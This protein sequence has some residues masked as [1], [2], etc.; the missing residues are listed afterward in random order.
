MSIRQKARQTGN[1]AGIA[2][3]LEVTTEKPGNVTPTHDF[4]D[5]KFENFIFGGLIIGNIVEKAFIDG[6]KEKFIPGKRIYEFVRESKIYNKTNTHFG[7]ALLFIPLAT[8]YGMMLKNNKSHKENFE[9]NLKNAIAHVMKKTDVDDVIYFHKAILLCNARVPNIEDNFDKFDKLDILSKNFIKTA[10]KENLTLYR[11]M[12]ISAGKDLIAKELTTKM[13]ISFKY[14]S[15]LCV[16]ERIFRDNVLFLFLSILS[17]FPDTLI[18]KKYGVEISEKVS[19]M[20]AD[21]FG[22]KLT[23]KKFSDYMHI[24]NINPGSTADITANVVFLYLLKKFINL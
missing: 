15:Q 17:E 12:E 9:K 18:T 14:F 19:K 23:L 5:T 11:L 21:V 7:I 10:K 24:N 22:G 8:A 2:C 16:H 20:A 1:F 13:N 6:Y 3:V 4:S